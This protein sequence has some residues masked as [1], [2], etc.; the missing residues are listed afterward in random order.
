MKFIWKFVME[1]LELFLVGKV[2]KK[3]VGRF[4][5]F[6]LSTSAYFFPAGAEMRFQEIRWRIPWSVLKPKAN[7][8]KWIMELKHSY[9]R[10]THGPLSL[11]HSEGICILWLIFV[12]LFFPNQLKWLLCPSPHLKVNPLY[13][14]Y[15]VH[16]HCARH[17]PVCPRLLR[18][19]PRTW[20]AQS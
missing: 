5:G 9:I 18:I 13:K 12:I 14:V 17:I 1:K 16:V 4:L 2:P 3:S 10:E 19:P 11:D 20:E 6:V 8:P 7:P 15:S